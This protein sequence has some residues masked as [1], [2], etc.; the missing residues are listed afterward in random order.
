MLY[1]L[2]TLAFAD[3]IGQC[4]HPEHL[5]FPSGDAIWQTVRREHQ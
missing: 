2:D 5:H 3:A 4:L 1:L